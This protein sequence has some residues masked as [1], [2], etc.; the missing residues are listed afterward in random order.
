MHPKN[1]FF[2]LLFGFLLLLISCDKQ[3]NEPTYNLEPSGKFL[4]FELDTISSNQSNGFQFLDPY[5]FSLDLNS[6]KVQIFD[7]YSGK[8]V[9]NLQ[10]EREGPDGVS[11]IFGFQVQSL[12]SIYL[13]SIGS[14]TVFLT[15]TTAQIVHKTN[16]ELPESVYNLFLSRSYYNSPPWISDG[17]LYGKTRFDVDI[18]TL[19]QEKLDQL[20]LLAGIDL[21]NGAMESVHY[22]FPP[23]YLN[24]GQKQLESSVIQTGEKTVVSFLGDHRL[25][26][27]DNL[28]EPLLPKEGR[29]Q[30]LE[31]ILPSFSR[32][33]SSP[34]FAKYAMAS[35]RYGSLVY[36]PY[37]DL[38]YRFAFPT[39]DIDE[40]EEL[41]KLMTEPGP[42]VLMVFDSDL[43][44]LTERKFEGGR[45]FQDNFFVTENGLYLSINHPQNPENKEDFMTFELIELTQVN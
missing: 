11:D 8:T 17:K 45:Y 18:K 41:R 26:F 10:F 5:L 43:T 29:S 23:D 9:K 12:D 44:L 42:F 15:D 21:K 25:Y 27:S 34:E 19:T 6:N 22:H 4:K 39:L 35:S 40:M 16:F 20:P 28:K 31:N 30:F 1:P 37:K 33:T 32:E 24:S 2:K 3:K 36:D 13:L 38:Y 14:K 7:V